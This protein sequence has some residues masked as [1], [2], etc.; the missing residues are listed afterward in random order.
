MH[1]F[2]IYSFIIPN[3]ILF[4][5]NI[6][7]R[8]FFLLA[9][10]SICLFVSCSKG[11]SGINNNPN[12]T[13][14]HPPFTGTII[15]VAGGNALGNGAN[16]LYN[17][18]SAHFDAAGNLYVC[19]LGNDRVQMFPPNSTSATNGTTVAGGNGAGSA[20]NQLNN[21][22]NEFIDSV[23]D[24]YIADYENNRVQ[25]WL[26]GADS[27]ITVA[28]GNGAGTGK[29]QLSGPAGV[30][31][32]RSG[33][34]YVAD[35]VSNRIQKFPPNSTSASDAVTVA[36]GNGAGSAANQFNDPISVYVDSIGNIY[37]DD[38]INN[39]IQKFPAG[40]TSA[41]NGTTVAGGTPGSAANC[42]SSPIGMSVDNAGNVYVADA[43]NNRI[44]KWAPGAVTG[45]TVAGAN[46]QGAAANQFDNMED[47]YV[48][49]N[50][51]MYISDGGNNRVQEWK[52]N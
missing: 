34:I 3:T 44:Q 37:V 17:P 49:A 1:K 26:S 32:D 47:V 33:N 20:A 6:M 15:T 23:G 25:E 13:L 30:F 5:F 24:I 7:K 40:S 11:S 21:P 14:P 28:G 12:D 27:G 16:E 2:V 43:G 50:G 10:S 9:I 29:N 4:K 19:D 36:G 42:L 45:V 18:V 8:I 48:D 35:E 31:V 22:Y 41:T 52:V 39:R 38:I 46:G 51:N